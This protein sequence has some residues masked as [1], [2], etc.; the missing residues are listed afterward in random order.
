MYYILCHAGL[1]CLLHVLL[2]STPL[3]RISISNAAVRIAC[4][5]ERPWDNGVEFIDV[6]QYYAIGYH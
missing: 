2:I 3:P 4:R 1:N 6:R 5:Y